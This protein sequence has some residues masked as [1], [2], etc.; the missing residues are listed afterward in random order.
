MVSEKVELLKKITLALIVTLWACLLEHAPKE[1]YSVY[2]L[3]TLLPYNY[4]TEYSVKYLQI[5]G[6]ASEEQER[7]INAILKDSI[8]EWL[9]QD[10]IWISRCQI[11]I[12]YQSPEY[13]SVC[14][15]LADNDSEIESPR[16][17]ICITIDIKAQKRIY[18]SDIVDCNYL[19]SYLMEYRY[20]NEF[21]P[22]ISFLEA[23][24]I[25]RYASMSEYEYIQEMVTQDE[26]VL[27]FTKTYLSCKPSFYLTENSVVIIR[28]EYDLNNIMIGREMTLT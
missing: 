20:E 24:N 23:Q 16:I 26:L 18:L 27:N 7:K 9:N 17:C 21:S 25:I 15:R 19:E 5:R 6:L 3:N 13:L 22:P 1:D 8:L 10:S 14:Y 2:Q 11:D 4:E 28:D 12:L